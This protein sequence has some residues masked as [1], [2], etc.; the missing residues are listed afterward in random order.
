MMD[1]RPSDRIQTCVERPYTTQREH[2]LAYAYLQR[3]HAEGTLLPIA[4][5]EGDPV[6]GYA[7]ILGIKQ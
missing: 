3:R 2:D 1:M 6:K 4:D 5:W 7:D